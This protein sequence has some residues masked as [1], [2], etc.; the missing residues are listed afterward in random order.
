M[1]PGTKLDAELIF[2]CR[3]LDASA[4]VT[5]STNRGTAGTTASS[6]TWYHG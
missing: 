3:K 4:P 5:L 2:D 6:Q 1:P